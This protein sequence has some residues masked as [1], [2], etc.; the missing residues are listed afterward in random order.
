MRI[1]KV[2]ISNLCLYNTSFKTGNMPRRDVRDHWMIKNHWI[3][4]KSLN[5]F[6][7]SKEPIH[8]WVGLSVTGN[9]TV[10]CVV[11]Y[12]WI[13]RISYVFSNTLINLEYY[14]KTTDTLNTL[15]S[16]NNNLVVVAVTCSDKRQFRFQLAAS[17]VCSTN[18]SLRFWVQFPYVA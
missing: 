7:G 2:I 16:K 17:K 15:E 3:G 12:S 9:T 4:S 5:R 6:L 10:C 11:L 14:M 13:S 1:Q 8:K 18:K